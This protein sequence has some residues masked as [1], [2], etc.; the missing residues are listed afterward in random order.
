MYL[1]PCFSRTGRLIWVHGGGDTTP[2]VAAGVTLRVIEEQS[3]LRVDIP[4]PT[5]GFQSPTLT[6][7]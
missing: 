3:G 6:P 7:S 2:Y 1:D 5:A 4:L